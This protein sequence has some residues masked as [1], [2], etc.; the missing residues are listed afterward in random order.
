MPKSSIVNDISAT[1]KFKIFRAVLLYNT[2]L[3]KCDTSFFTKT[4]VLENYK[5]WNQ[6]RKDRLEFL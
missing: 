6:K 5:L 4:T 1:F 3:R 2:E